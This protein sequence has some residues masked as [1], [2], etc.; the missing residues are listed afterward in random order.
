MLRRDMTRAGIAYEDAAGR[1]FDFHAFR[2][3]FISNL[4]RAGVHPK[5]A[6]VLARHSTITLTMDRYA[7]VG[8][9]DLRGALDRLPG[10]PMADD[11][12]V[13]AAGGV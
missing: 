6:Q 1:V 4:A 7:H 10:L 12:A 5:V 9:V 3:G 2:H 8:I 11:G 13:V